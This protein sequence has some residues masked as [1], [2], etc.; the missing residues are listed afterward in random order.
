MVMQPS[1]LSLNLS[2]LVKLLKAATLCLMVRQ[3]SNLS[4]NLSYLVKRLKAAALCLMVMQSSNLSWNLSYLA[5]LLKAA[6]LC[7]LVV[8]PSNLDSLSLSPSFYPWWLLLQIGKRH[9]RSR[10]VSA[11][12][13]EV[14]PLCAL[15]IVDLSVWEI[16]QKEVEYV[17]PSACSLNLL[18]KRFARV[19]LES[20]PSSMLERGGKWKLRQ[21]MARGRIS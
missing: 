14:S 10:E 21:K 4:W 3:S 19:N 1:N 17:W 18:T 11:H 8:Q 9:W 7:L 15:V 2:Y 20:Q 12:I 13:L 16:C 5:K 6:A